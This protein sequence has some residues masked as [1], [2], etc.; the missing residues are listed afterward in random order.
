MKVLRWIAVSFS[1]FSRIPMPHFKWEEDDMSHCLTFFPWVGTVIGLLTYVAAFC[2][3]EFVL[4]LWA[5]GAL[6]LL[7]PIFVT[8]GFHLDGYMDVK[9]A[10]S[11]YADR[12]KKLE[13]LKDPN[14]GSFAIIGIITRIIIAYVSICMILKYGDC[15]SW[16]VLA[17][18]FWNSRCLSGLTS[19]F[20]PKAR[21]SGM[22]YSETKESGKKSPDFL[23][24]ELLLG[25]AATLLND[26]KIGI[27]MIVV[28]ALLVLFYKKKTEK[29]FGGVTGDT[30]GYFI[31]CF[32]SD[33]FLMM[34]VLLCLF[35]KC[36]MLRYL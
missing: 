29:E 14:V 11:S 2:Y 15:R 27:V 23:I 20:F 36:D 22:L 5:I 4:P 32:E 9:D 25:I 26:Y 17:L 7:I 3:D 13:I 16:V 1:M 31:V 28:G 24:V 6:I 30:A 18:V 8:G 10:L 12:E 35:T 34:A 19:I 21:K 33:M